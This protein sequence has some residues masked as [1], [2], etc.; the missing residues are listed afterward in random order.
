M[1]FSTFPGLCN[2]HPPSDFGILSSSPKETLCQLTIFPQSL[3]TPTPFPGF[4]QP[5]IYCLLLWICLFWTLGK[6]GLKQDACDGLLWLRVIFRVVFH[7]SA[8]HYLILTPFYGVIIFICGT[9]PHC[10]YFRSSADGHL[11][12]FDPK[13]DTGLQVLVHG[14]RRMNSA[15]TQAESKQSLYYRAAGRGEKSPLSLLSSRGF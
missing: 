13:D 14:R 11:S 10:V 12:G 9:I 15:N 4:R 7:C 3:K 5:L 8:H 1:V 2:H 6:R